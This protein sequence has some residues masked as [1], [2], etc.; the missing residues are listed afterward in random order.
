MLQF[1]EA[2]ATDLLGL[3]ETLVFVIVAF[4][5]T[6]KLGNPK[7]LQG[8]FD[9][10]MNKY[11]TEQTIKKT[12]GQKF[13]H[14]APVYEYDAETGELVKTDKIINV[15]ELVNSSKDASLNSIYDR[16]LPDDEE[17]SRAT[18]DSHNSRELT[19]DTLRESYTVV[20]N[21]REKYKLP[22]DMDAL[23]V[24]DYVQKKSKQVTEAVKVATETKKNDIGGNNDGEA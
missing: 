21:Y 20:E 1:L 8:A 22:D 23:A 5:L 12:V 11:K 13:P 2:Y 15:D 7:Y 3:I 9:I 18:F 14:T 10:I 24:L 6:K 16:F 4:V 17:R 19:L